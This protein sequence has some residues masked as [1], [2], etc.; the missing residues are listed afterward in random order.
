MADLTPETVQALL[1]AITTPGIEA[2]A[3][4]RI[5]VDTCH[6]DDRMSFTE[7]EDGLAAVSMLEVRADLLPKVCAAL[8]TAWEDLA[9]V[10]AERDRLARGADPLIRWIVVR[11][12]LADRTGRACWHLGDCMTPHRF[13]E[14]E[15]E[16]EK[17]RDRAGLDDHAVVPVYLNPR[18]AW[19]DRAEVHHV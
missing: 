4:A 6:A 7:L 19:L 2:D 14:T 3:L 5:A 12:E 17:A 11:S 9:R 10:T 16:A 8:L 18:S 15:A 13:Y 1:S